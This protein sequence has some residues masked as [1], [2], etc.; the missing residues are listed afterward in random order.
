[1]LLLL[2]LLVLAL[3]LVAVLGPAAC[4]AWLLFSGLSAGELVLSGGLV[5]EL[6]LPV[7][8]ALA[9]LPVLAV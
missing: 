7:T 3:G 5:L 8:V 4:V 6:E 9:V 1:V 2:L